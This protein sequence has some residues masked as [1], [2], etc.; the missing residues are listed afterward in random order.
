MTLVGKRLVH[1]FTV[2]DSLIF[3]RD[4]LRASLAAGMQVSVVSSEGPLLRKLARELPV[5]VF[6]VEMPRRLGPMDDLAAAQAIFRIISKL[7]PHIVHAHTPKGGLLGSL[8]AHAARVPVRIYQMRGLPH[9]T[10]QGAMRA[11][12]MTT[13][14]IACRAATHVLCEG[15]SLRNVAVTEGL[16]AGP[17]ATVLL[18]GSNGVDCQMRFVPNRETRTRERLAQ[19]FS[20]EE[21]VFLFV[22]RLVRDKGVGE[23]LHSFVSLRKGHPLVRLVIVGPLEERDALGPHEKALLT[24]Q[25]VE[26]VGYQ[27]DVVRFYSAADVVVLPS[28]REGFPNVP[29]EAAA[30][31][32][33]VITTNA[34]GCVDA[35]DP[36]VTGFQVPVNNVAALT[37]TMRAYATDPALRD[38]HGLAGRAWVERNFEMNAMTTAVLG[39]YSRALEENEGTVD[40]DP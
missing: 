11:L 15:Y 31:G 3:V 12:L 6:A 35:V 22:G 13:E 30:M 40:A 34:V 20:P 38:R 33:P 29:L 21:V 36:G 28:H 7:Q 37:T 26:H 17:K 27:S 32:L 2:S 18:H 23:L 39:F 19:G 8:A 10:Q 4:Q 5:E 9:V 14:R 24:A 1:V 16:V 25:G